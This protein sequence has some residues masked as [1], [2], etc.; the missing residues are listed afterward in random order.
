VSP[1]RPNKAPRAL[2]VEDRRPQRPPASGT[3][4]IGA[5]PLCQRFGIVPM[6]LGRWLDNP[7]LAFPRP[8][9]VNNRRYWSLAEIER[10][11]RERAIKSAH[12]ARDRI[13]DIRRLRQEVS[14]AP[15]RAE[16]RTLLA[17]IL[18]DSLLPTEREGALAELADIMRELPESPESV[19]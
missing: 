14:A 1:A 19:A 12:K 6:T 18:F 17:D 15:S 4:H 13:L 9:F 7:A 10:W 5:I 16:A 3:V 11:E 2:Q 8:Y